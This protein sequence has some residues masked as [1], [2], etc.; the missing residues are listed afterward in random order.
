M[1]FR[2]KKLKEKDIAQLRKEKSLDN[3]LILVTET[4]ERLN[5]PEYANAATDAETQSILDKCIEVFCYLFKS[6][7]LVKYYYFIK[8]SI[9]LN[10]V[11]RC[12]DI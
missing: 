10:K 4:R 3:L 8:L 1:L 11:T 7:L 12:S 5:Q 2:L 6:K 9:N